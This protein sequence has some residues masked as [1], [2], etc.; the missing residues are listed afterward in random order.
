MNKTY[1]FIQKKEGINKTVFNGLAK[2]LQML[3]WLNTR[4][5]RYI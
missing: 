3:A 2:I 5:I 4:K 1:K